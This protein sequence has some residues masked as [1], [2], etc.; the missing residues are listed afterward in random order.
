MATKTRII[1]AN[2]IMEMQVDTKFTWIPEK[3]MKRIKEILFAFEIDLSL[4]NGK[5]IIFQ[6]VRVALGFNSA[7]R[8]KMKVDIPLDGTPIYGLIKPFHHFENRG[9][10]YFIVEQDED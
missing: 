2:K 10:V 9:I 8:Y 5:G 7:N 4:S 1:R 6:D 3:G